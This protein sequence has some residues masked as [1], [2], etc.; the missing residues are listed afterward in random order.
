MKEEGHENED[1][2]SSEG[3]VGPVPMNPASPPYPISPSDPGVPQTP[4]NTPATG[5]GNADVNSQPSSINTD[6]FAA[7]GKPPSPPVEPEKPGGFEPFV[8]GSAQA[9]DPKLFEP[10]KV[11]V[12]LSSEQIAKAQK[13]C[14]W[15]GSALNYDDVPTAVE[16][17][18]FAL[19]LLQTGQD[20]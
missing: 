11:N 9:I 3:A 4:Q 10:P 2:S 20:K 14:K 5:F 6:P 7:S 17:L 16:N 12:N 15:A 13:Y 18:Q 1:V 19:R 8:P